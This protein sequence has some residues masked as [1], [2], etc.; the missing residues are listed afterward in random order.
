MWN[1]TQM[2]VLH[3]E[4][5]L[6]NGLWW[7]CNG[8]ANSLLEH[9]NHVLGYSYVEL[10]FAWTD[11]CIMFM[12]IWENYKTPMM[13]LWKLQTIWS[14]LYQGV[15][16]GRS[17]VSDWWD[18]YRKNPPSDWAEISM[19]LHVDTNLLILLTLINSIGGKIHM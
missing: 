14:C 12:F 18:C 11:R 6:G 2:K 4:I 8:H 13:N 1:N 10:I 17:H 3:L 9:S 16:I 15:R 19:Y 5:I 7:Q